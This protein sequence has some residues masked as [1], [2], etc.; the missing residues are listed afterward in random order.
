MAGWVLIS[1]VLLFVAVTL[2]GRCFACSGVMLGGIPYSVVIAWRKRSR[3]FAIVAVLFA[4]FFGVGAT[5]LVRRAPSGIGS[6][7]AKVMSIFAEGRVSHRQYA[8]GNL[9]PEV[10]QLMLGF[11]L[12]PTIDSLF[13][14]L[15]SSELKSWTAAIYRE[16]DHD[17]DFMALGSAMPYAYDELLENGTQWGHSYLYIPASVDRSKPS[18]VLI[19][20]H[21]SGGNFKAYL[22]LL[23]QVADKLNFVVL[24]P[25]FGSGNWRWPETGEVVDAALAAAR[26]S[27]AIAH[28]NVHVMGLSNGGLAVSQL[29]CNRGKKYRSLIFLSPVFDPEF[30]HSDSFASECK[31]NNVFVLTGGLDDRVPLVYVRNNAL[32]IS[33]VGAKVT[34]NVEDTAGHFLFFSH[35]ER[36]LKTLEAWLAAQSR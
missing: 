34:L 5:V 24:A 3:H 33:K 23:V 30:L 11:T 35:R 12:M 13:T 18:P 14:R 6:S 27:V 32:E 8:L 25:S 4:I 28:D 26:R 10:D 36:V 31:Q 29:A 15:Q 1:L 9:L 16:L 21:G 20:L 17:R 19:F 2:E 22:W 7:Q